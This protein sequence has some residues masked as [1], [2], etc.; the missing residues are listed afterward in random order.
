MKRI[1]CPKCG[2]AVYKSE[3]FGDLSDRKDTK[4]HK[5]DIKALGLGASYGGSFKK[6][7]CR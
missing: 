2:K 5:K 1:K 7:K 3:K 4:R 6:H